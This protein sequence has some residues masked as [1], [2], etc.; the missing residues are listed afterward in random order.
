MFLEQIYI[1]QIHQKTADKEV[2]IQIVET[3]SIIEKN[4]V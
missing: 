2:G 4:V 1:L 3:R